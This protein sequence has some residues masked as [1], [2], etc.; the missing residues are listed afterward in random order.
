[1]LTVL[2]VGK[3]LS[4]D[5]RILCTHV[6]ISFLATVDFC[7]LGDDHKPSGIL[8]LRSVLFE[9]SQGPSKSTATKKVKGP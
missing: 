2:E 3:Q 9:I 6:Q 7:I 1:M 8:E 4:T 5:A